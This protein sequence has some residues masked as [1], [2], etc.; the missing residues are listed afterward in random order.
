M[1]GLFLGRTAGHG[2][3]GIQNIPFQ[4]DQFILM[5]IFFRQLYGFIQ[6]LHYNDS[7][8]QIQSDLS[9]F[10]IESNQ[11]ISCADDADLCHDGI[12][13]LQRSAFNGSH[14][15]ESGS[16][17]VIAFQIV[18]GIF[19]I[20][21]CFGNNILQSTAQCCFDGSFIFFLHLQ[22]LTNRTANTSFRRIMKIQETFYTVIKPFMFFF[23]FHQQRQT[24][25]CLRNT[26]FLL[27]KAGF[28][29]LFLFCRMTSVMLQS[30]QFLFQIANMF[31][32]V[33]FLFFQCLQMHAK[34]MQSAFG[35]FHFPVQLFFSG[36][37]LGFHGFTL[38]NFTFGFCA[39]SNLFKNLILEGFRFI[40]ILSQGIAQGSIFFFQRIQFALLTVHFQF[41][42][43][44]FAFAGRLFGFVFLL[45][46]GFFRH[47]L[48]NTADICRIILSLFLAQ[49]DLALSLFHF[50]TKFRHFRVLLLQKNVQFFGFCSERQSRFLFRIT[51]RNAVCQLFSGSGFI[52]LQF[53][54]LGCNTFCIT[55]E[56]RSLRLF[57]VFLQSQIFLRLFTLFC[58][59]AH[60]HFQFTDDIIHTEQI[61]LFLFQLMNSF[62]LSGFIFYDT[63]R[64]LKNTT[65]VIAFCTQNFIDTPLPDDGI[66]LT[67][68]A[69][70][71]EQFL[72]IL[73]TA[74]STVDAVFALAGAEHPSGH[75][76]LT[77]FQ[78]QFAVLII[79]Q[80]RNLRKAQRLSVL[81]TGKD[82][83]FHLIAT[84]TLGSLFPQYPAHGIRDIT[85]TA[86]VGPNDRRHTGVEFQFYFF[87]KGFETL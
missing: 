40:F 54:Q 1:Q 44:P 70:I 38:G 74:G 66:P 51:F 63:C 61:L 47:F 10:F 34:L 46:S 75:L 87:R 37:E 16:A 71:H 50:C 56:C 25:T 68:N 76:H 62:V 35:I 73:Q 69:R 30:I 48:L 31:F 24:G 64:F 60:L 5:T 13:A 6:I 82:D 29:P 58:Q 57:Q 65:A 7:A 78:R 81:R 43:V 4:S 83:I 33:V 85:F 32:S 14:R 2:T 3:T 42:G 11:I 27:G 36:K 8:Q 67:A 26:L 49:T 15:Q 19:R 39:N 17:E 72:N 18:D 21:F 79:D 28:R 86:A 12:L 77:V 23:H 55:A 59:R 20:F 22:Q 45:L 80:D 53:F 41:Q 9:E 84:E 52:L